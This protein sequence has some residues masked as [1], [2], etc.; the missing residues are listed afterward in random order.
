MNRWHLLAPAF[1]GALALAVFGD[2]PGAEPEVV[3]AV[4]ARSSHALPAAP[5]ASAPVVLGRLLDRKALFAASRAAGARSD[6]FAGHDWTPPAPA[7]ATVD[8]GPE[9][10]AF[11]F[12]YIGK[13]REAGAWEVFLAKDESTFVLKEGQVA[14][15][16]YQVVSIAP[17]EMTV[18]YLPMNHTYK[19]SIGE[20]E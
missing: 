6:L 16:S 1:L 14:E 2:K 11:P 15:Q 5:A 7:A 8:A 17:P 9:A 18:V 10:P 12:E 19:I 20:A 13:K 3:A 4:P